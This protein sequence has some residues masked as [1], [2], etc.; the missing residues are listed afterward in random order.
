[1][2]ADLSNPNPPLTRTAE[3]I[4]SAPEGEA[5]SLSVQ[6]P[7]SFDWRSLNGHNYVSPVKNQ[8]SCGSCWAFG[9]VGPMESR[10]LIS[11]AGLA[12]LSEQYLVS[13]N[14]SGWSCGGG[15]WAHDYH[16]NRKVPAE[17]EP[18]SVLESV[19]PYTGSN[20]SCNAP[21][22]HSQKLVRWSY[23]GSSY[24]VPSVEAIKN[25]IATYGPV[26][27]AVCVGSS[28]S[29][30]RS[31]IF[32]TDEKSACNGSVNHAVVLVG[33]DDATDTWIMKNS[34]GTGWGESGYM[35][36]KRGVSNIGYAAN[37][38]VYESSPPPPPA[39]FTATNWV[40]LPL[41]YNQSPYGVKNGDFENGPDGTWTITSTFY[42]GEEWYIILDFSN[43]E[44]P[45]YNHSGS[46]AAWLGGDPSEVTTL[47]Q[48]FIVPPDATQLEYWYWIGSNDSCGLSFATV[49]L[50]GNPLR[51]PYD[52]CQVSTD[53]VQELI[54]IP[55]YYRG[56]TVNLSF[57]ARIA[58]DPSMTFFSDFLLDDI[59]ILG[60]LSA[61]PLKS[62]I[63]APKTRRPFPP[64]VRKS[65]LRSAE[66]GQ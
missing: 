43:Y 6:L 7:A 32:A 42:Q 41:V 30:Y 59:S 55:P 45:Y 49:T 51:L 16:V 2:V 3:T 19:F 4:S 26:A 10:L 18:G 25:A 15:W 65:T 11:G 33:W 9:T 17:L 44:V 34:W 64:G 58:P 28:F 37:Y 46:Y 47:S 60:P 66:K 54:D 53:W 27:V 1:M 23:V 8:G 38:V 56:R 63:Q 62:A 22:A 5:P 52:L 12:D 29:G 50:D 21:H 31:G 57:E 48:R 36:I 24:G 40:Y 20:S 61:R 39:Q 14:S 13:C 35:R